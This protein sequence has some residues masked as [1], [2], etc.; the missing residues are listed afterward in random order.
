MHPA[1][2]ALAA[3]GQRRRHHDYRRGCA[4]H[5]PASRALPLC[6]V[7]RTLVLSDEGEHP[8]HDVFT[9]FMRAGVPV[10]IP[11]NEMMGTADGPGGCKIA[12]AVAAAKAAAVR[13]T[14]LAFAPSLSLLCSE[15]GC[16]P[17]QVVVLCLGTTSQND[18]GNAVA[19]EGTD[20]GDF[21]LPASQAALARAIFAHAQTRHCRVLPTLEKEVS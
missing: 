4:T 17:A 19:H 15:L 12:A 11:C 2:R 5:A 14:L 1:D 7:L 3:A 18:E 13:P 21:T 20:R 16:H 10:N 9:C 8:C 6:A